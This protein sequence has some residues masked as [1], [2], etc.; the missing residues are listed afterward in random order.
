MSSGFDLEHVGEHSERTDNGA[1]IENEIAF[2]EVGDELED[3]E[4]DVRLL[5][6]RDRMNS[7]KPSRRNQMMFS[8]GFF[9]EVL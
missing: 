6:V 8:Y 5:E 1:E 7:R 4:L 2:V 9:W 3:V